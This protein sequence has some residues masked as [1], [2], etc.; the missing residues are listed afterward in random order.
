M[1]KVSVVMITYGHEKYIAQAVNG[2]L[3]QE[4]DFPVELI[5]A[6]DCSPDNTDLIIKDFIENH[7]KGGT[8][9]YIKHEKNVGMISNLI[10][11]IEQTTGDYIALC[12]GDDYWTDPMKLQKQVNFLE[13]NPDYAM[14]IHNV[15][16]LKEDGKK[17]LFAT[18]DKED[19]TITDLAKGNFISTLSVVY[20]VY[21]EKFPSYFHRIFLGDYVLNMH[22]AMN[23]KIRLINEVMGVYRLHG[24][25][26]WSAR[27]EEFKLIKAA[28]AIAV[29]L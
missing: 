17:T 6:N 7:S 19:F 20:R 21:K 27:Q 24:Q 28:E 16:N 4:C 8:I 18:Y 10:S 13:A 25:S 11:A 12:E 9:N 23:G 2:V 22:V 29:Q 1:A 5:I 26:V 15:M 14:C 3:M